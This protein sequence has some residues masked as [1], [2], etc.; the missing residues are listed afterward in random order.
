MIYIYILVKI[1]ILGYNHR[2]YTAYIDT[3]SQVNIC[4]R[5]CLPEEIWKKL[6]TSMIISSFTK[7]GSMIDYKT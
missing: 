1:L 2:Y 3:G 6:R 5:N 7:D 4:K